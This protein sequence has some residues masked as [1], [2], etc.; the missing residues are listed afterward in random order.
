MEPVA[1]TMG[2]TGHREQVS[3]VLDRLESYEQLH[4]LLVVAAEPGRRFTIVELTDLKAAASD[5]EVIAADL[6]DAGLLV[7]DGDDGLR[8]AAEVWVIEGAA[9]L[10]HEYLNNPLPIIQG[11]TTRAM[12]RLRSA[13][14]RTFADAF[15]VR[16][17]DS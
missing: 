16:R 8:L 5:V 9:G 17:R 13:T 3:R 11:L 14:A 12:E 7:R 15:V 10:T 2:E 1:R 4:L 6:I